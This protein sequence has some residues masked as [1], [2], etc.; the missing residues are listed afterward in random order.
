[1]DVSTERR[2]LVRL[3]WRTLEPYHAVTYFARDAVGAYPDAGV[4]GF[5]RGYF[6]GRASPLGRVG[7]GAVTAIFYGFAPEFVRRAVP[8]IW[9]SMPPDRA[10]ATRLQGID[11]SVR[12]DIGLEPVLAAALRVLPI[13]RLPS[14]LDTAGRPMF[15][16]NAELDVADEPHLALWQLATLLREHRG[17]GHVAALVTNGVGPAEAHLLRLATTGVDPA[18]IQPYRGWTEGD[19]AMAAERLHRDGWIDHSGAV[20]AR[21][22]DVYRRV[23]SATDGAAAA[24]IA[25][26]DESDALAIVD[27]MR[28]VLAHLVRRVIPYPNAMGVPEP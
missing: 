3:V 22:R 18:S 9:D 17:D 12:A 20:T 11:Q 15:A 4:T 25:H 10:V 26:L 28:P 14:D 24:F 23:E 21:G 6:A 19:W 27:A 7:A 1:M 8:S 13:L 5:W 16:A 2:A